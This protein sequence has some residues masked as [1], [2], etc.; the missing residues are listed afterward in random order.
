MEKHAV[1]TEGGSATEETRKRIVERR[2]TYAGEDNK[3]HE[4]KEYEV[5]E[6]IPANGGD[7]AGYWVTSKMHTGIGKGMSFARFGCI[8]HAKMF[9]EGKIGVVSEETVYDT[10]SD[11][12]E[13]ETTEA[14]RTVYGDGE[15]R[16]VP[17]KK[18]QT[19]GL[20]Q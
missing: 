14:A 19:D 1:K 8:D 20:Q 10:G 4:E 13:T 7:F 16:F 2:L 9:I 12:A 18:E 15:V 17:H 3:I 11:A 6:Y 5:Q